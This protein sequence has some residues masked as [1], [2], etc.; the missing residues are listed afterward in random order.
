MKWSWVLGISCIGLVLG[1]A[2]A[3]TFTGPEYFGRVNT[4]II[5]QASGLALS[6][7]D[8]RVLWT[9][10]DQTDGKVFALGTNGVL[11]ASFNLNYPVED[12]E[13]IAVTPAHGGLGPMMYVGDLGNNFG[14]R[15][16]VRILRAPEPAVDLAWAAAPRASSLS[17]VEVFTLRYPDGRFNAEPLLVDHLG[18]RL[19]LLTKTTG[20]A[21]IYSA[22]LAELQSS[23]VNTLSFDGEIY[24]PQLT[25]GTISADGQ[26]IALRSASKATLWRR[27][28]GESVVNALRRTGVP[29]PVVGPPNEP[30]GEGITFAASSDSAGYFTISEGSQ[31]PLHFFRSTNAG[32]ASAQWLGADNTS[33][34]TWKGAYGLEGF[35]IYG[36]SAALPPYA[37]LAFSAAQTG[38]WHGATTDLR[39]LERANGTTSGRIAACWYSPTQFSLR[40][41]FNDGVAHEVA[42]YL[43]DWDS[44]GRVQQVDVLDAN[45]GV[46]LHSQVVGSFVGGRYLNYLLRGDVL[47]RFSRLQG[48]NAVIS[49][50]FFDAATGTPPPSVATPTITP[51]GGSFTAPVTLTLSSATAGATIHY[52]LDG[53]SP[54]TASTH[55]TGPF[56]LNASATVSA[57]AF[58]NGT[59][60]AVQRASFQIS[61]PS[62]GALRFLGADFTTQGNWR[63]TLGRNGFFVAEDWKSMAAGFQ[64]TPIGAASHIWAYNV[65]D[66]AA[67][68]KFSSSGRIASCWYAS[69]AYEF[70][71]QVPDGL[72]TQLAIYFLDWDAAGRVQ[73]VQ[74]LSRSTGAVLDTREVR[75][76]K[77]GVYLKWELTS[78][79]RVRLSRFTGP[80]A[81][82]SGIFLD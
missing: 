17:A 59:A 20:N 51:N 44:G 45:T 9:H 63:G 24:F 65:S 2:G 73:Q 31:P 52:T 12:L 68:Q 23:G 69:G 19:Y 47:L 75:E 38:I 41:T 32:Q 36:D 60:S 16:T 57:Q 40:L 64:V 55:Y 81:V 56:Q 14:G 15:E 48:Y 3:Q 30:N 10:N 33:R 26:T 78:G 42:F 39:A 46:V 72:A 77:T 79:V 67:L 71:V 1:G 76:F 13:D 74:L 8:Q 37:Q 43:L 49:G 50:I 25:A 27:N 29:I 21:R 34:G 18:G 62:S 61:S 4:P 28:N 7:R 35:N 54:T 5:D 70:D 11:L 80:N 58:A 53:T 82:A 22:A 6:M 66:V